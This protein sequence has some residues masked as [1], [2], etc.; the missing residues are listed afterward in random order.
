MEVTFPTAFHFQSST[1]FYAFHIPTPFTRNC[2]V[3][4]GLSDFQGIAWPGDSVPWCQSRAKGEKWSE[5][6]E[7]S[8]EKHF[9]DD[10]MINV[11]QLIIYL[12][13]S[14]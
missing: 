2:F 8:W 4:P 13:N 6:W 7:N 3:I 14:K 11:N 10:D 1:D 5:L 12:S 9:L